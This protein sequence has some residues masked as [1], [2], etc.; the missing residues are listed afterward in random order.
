M[1]RETLGNLVFMVRLGQLV[2]KARK[3]QQERPVI[4]VRLAIRGPLDSQDQWGPQGPGDR[5]VKLDPLDQLDLRD[6]LAESCLSNIFD[7][8]AET[9]FNLRFQQSF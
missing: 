3:G 8:Y 9:S 4:G 5:V 1:K 7:R 2:K 6:D